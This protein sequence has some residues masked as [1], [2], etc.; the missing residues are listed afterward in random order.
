MV[1][2]IIMYSLSASLANKWAEDDGVDY[3]FGLAGNAT[4]D[5]LVAETADNLRFHHAQSSQTKL[6]TYASFTYQAGSWTRP[7]KVVARLECSLQP[8]DGEDIT[9]TGMRQGGRHPLCCHLAQGVGAASL[10]ERLLPARADGESDQADTVGANG[11]RSGIVVT[12]VARRL[13]LTLA[14]TSMG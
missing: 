14:K 13:S 1:A 3:I 11:F 6:R 10:R 9:S 2:S 8:A 12:H 5:A 4:L 7:R